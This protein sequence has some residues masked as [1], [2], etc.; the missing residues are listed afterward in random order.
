[1]KFNFLITLLLTSSMLSAAQPVAERVVWQGGDTITYQRIAPPEAW[2]GE[3]GERLQVLADSGDAGPDA[4][5]E[6]AAVAS[7]TLR[8]DEEAEWA[9]VVWHSQ[10]FSIHAVGG[11]GSEIRWWDANARQTRR[12]YSNRS[13]AYLP[14]V[15]E[16]RLD[17]DYFSLHAFVFE[18][19]EA[20]VAMDPELTA[21]LSRLARHGPADFAYEDAHAPGAPPTTETER[22]MLDLLHAHHEAHFAEL[23]QAREAA[24]AH[25]ELT[26]TQARLEAAQP[27]HTVVRFWPILSRR[28]TTETLP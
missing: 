21:R 16:T 5:G 7:G 12:V 24:L 10:F 9:G 2:R 27:R 23:K 4:A 19:E 17:D 1:M 6:T 3:V 22:R 14:H 28:H 8:P 13:L 25:A 15:I 11:L 20:D 26:A 18:L